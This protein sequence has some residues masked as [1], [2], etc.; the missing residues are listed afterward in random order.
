MA[1]HSRE[2]WIARGQTHHEQFNAALCHNIA[3]LRDQSNQEFRLIRA[4]D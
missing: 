3:Q 2:A 4:G 1:L